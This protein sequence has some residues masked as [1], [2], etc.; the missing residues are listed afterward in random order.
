MREKYRIPKGFQDVIPPDSLLWE[1][2]ES[3][4]RKIFRTYGYLEVR[5]PLLEHTEIFVRSIGE[6]TDIVEKEMYTFADRA[7]RSLTL[8][9]EGTAPVVR[10]YVQNGLHVRPTPQK[11]FYQGPMFRYERPQKGRFRQFYQIGAEAFGV[12]DPSIDA[13]VVLMLRDFLSA[14][15]LKDLSYEI[16][17]VGC[18]QCR[19]RFRAALRE[20]LAPR[21]PGLCADCQRRHETNPLR[22]LDCKV[23]ACIEGSAGA[24]VI[25]GHLCDSCKDHFEQ[26]RGYLDSMGVNAVLNPRLVRGL[27]YY[28]STTFEITTA[29]LGA[30]KAV[31]AG[32]RYNGLVEEFGGPPTPAVGFA[33]GMERLAELVSRLGHLKDPKPSLY[34]AGLDQEACAL[35]MQ[36]ARRVRQE[37]LWVELNYSPAS[38]RSLLKKADRMG[39]PVVFIVGGDEVR[40]GIVRFRRLSDGSEGSLAIADYEGMVSLVRGDPAGPGGER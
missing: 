26:F 40:E 39:V 10:C 9:P 12:E 5:V 25:T 16:N 8:R 24:P 14:I 11:F 33:V 17:S 1:F 18:P 29:H 27:D 38:L 31:A 2:I 32:G 20:F 36:I 30:Q 21:L 28:T 3:S 35:A 19:P 4:A 34:I 23:P 15:G 37:G 7:G 22:I 13:E 6:A